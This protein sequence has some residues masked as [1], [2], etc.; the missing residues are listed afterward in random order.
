[1]Q[2]TSSSQLRN[3]MLMPGL[4]KLLTVAAF[5]VAIW[6][7]GSMA[8]NG[9]IQ[10][11]DRQV[12]LAEWWRLGAGPL[13]AVVAALMTSAGIMMLGRY[14]HARLLYVVAWV[15]LCISIPFVAAVADIG[16]AA[17]RSSLIS[18]ALLTVAIAMYL[19]FS[20]AA[21]SYF[22]QSSN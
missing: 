7:V 11:G 22:S 10:V 12:S 2:V 4:L 21:R 15:G 13:L 8:P 1:M 17:S 14:R 18:N 3:F 5:G 20:K 9:S 6:V 19:Y 16:I